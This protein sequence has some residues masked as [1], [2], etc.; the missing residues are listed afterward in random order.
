[1]GLP[2]PQDGFD[3]PCC[4]RDEGG[5]CLQ[6]HEQKHRLTPSTKTL[7]AS[8]LVLGGEEAPAPVLEESPKS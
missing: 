3:I 8:D 7:V 5:A 4:M 2:S 6:E 1:M